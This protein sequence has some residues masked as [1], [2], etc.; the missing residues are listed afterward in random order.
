[1]W[2]NVT[3]ELLDEMLFGVPSED[4]REAMDF[5]EKNTARLNQ[6][7]VDRIKIDEPE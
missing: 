1:M 3:E 5:Y 6:P 4:D 2:Y 7:M